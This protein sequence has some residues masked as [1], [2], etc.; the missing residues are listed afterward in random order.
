[1]TNEDN[2]SFLVSLYV[3]IWHNDV[4]DKDFY[5][6]KEFA[7]KFNVSERTIRRA[8]KNCRISIIR[9]GSS[10][11]SA[12]RIAHSEIYR[13]SLIDLQAMAKKMIEQEGK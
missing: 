12:I 9:V 7:D 8:I 4:M 11:R 5:S 2:F 10:P 3:L 13:M 1:M 6:V